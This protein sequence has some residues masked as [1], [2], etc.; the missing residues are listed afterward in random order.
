MEFAERAN[1]YPQ[2]VSFLANYPQPQQVVEAMIQGPLAHLNVTSGHLYCVE[3]PNSLVLVG[4]TSHTPQAISRYQSIPR[5]I[6]MPMT[7]AV[8]EMSI[9]VTRMSQML[10]TYPALKMDEA[11]WQ[12]ELELNGDQTI[13]ASPII[14]RG[15]GVGSFTFLTPADYAWT[16]SDHGFVSGMSGWP[17]LPQRVIEVPVRPANGHCSKSGWPATGDSAT[18]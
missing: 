15:I 13:V 5:N 18:G 12:R 16:P 11:I 17:Q 14:S 3:P 8:R 2:F 9:E 6:D 4:S 10:E 1:V 7:K